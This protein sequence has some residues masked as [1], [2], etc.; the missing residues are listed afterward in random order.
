MTATRR[1]FAFCRG[2]AS[3]RGLWRKPFLMSTIDLAASP[4]DLRALAEQ[5]NAWPFE[6][7]KAIVARLKKTAKGR[8]AVRDRLRPVGPAAYRHLRR[9]RAHHH[10]AP[11]LSRADRGQDQDAA[12]RVFRRHGRPAQGAGQ[13]AEQGDADVASRQA[14]D[15]GFP[16]RSPTNIRRS[17]RT[18]MRGCAPSSTPSDSTTSSPAR[19]TT[20][21]RESS[22]PRCCACWSGSTR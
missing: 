1:H 12:A 22:T 9:G 8:G 20:T 16:I 10:G 7:A 5:S 19:P 11:R 17:A 2:S 15:A 18:T 6:Q 21:R 14:A 4:A 13:R 3:F